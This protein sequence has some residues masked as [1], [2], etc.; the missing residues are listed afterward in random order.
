MLGQGAGGR[1]SAGGTGAAG[2]SSLRNA[3]A[4]VLPFTVVDAEY[5]KSLDSVV[6][7][8]AKPD[9]LH[10]L[11]E[12]GSDIVVALPLAGAAVSV[13]PDGQTAAVGH[14]GWVTEVDLTSGAILQTV[15][16]SAPTLDI[17]LAA[18]HYAYVFPTGNQPTDIRSLNL[19][20]GKEEPT[21]DGMQIQGGTRAKLEPG[22]AAIYGAQNGV[23]EAGLERYDISAG[24]EQYSRAWPYHGDYAA[25]GDLWF[26][27]DGQRIFTRCGE[28]FDATGN[29]DAD[30]TYSGALE[31][32]TG[33]DLVSFVAHSAT[34]HQ[35]IALRGPINF[36]N[37]M[38]IP[39][40][41]TIVV[42]EDVYLQQERAIDATS[43]DGTSSLCSY[44]FA[45]STG[46]HAVLLCNG[47]DGQGSWLVKLA[48]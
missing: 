42:F 14:D 20:T 6:A 22:T 26:S 47:A 4:T 1:A 17:V 11:D 24:A 5:S 29:P 23:S 27:E 21:R 45:S 33:A 12:S 38:P 46:T 13:A 10:V 48:L 18:N 9:E 25:C 30:M 43:I 39:G 15:H 19:T 34:A 3:R 16:V 44:V 28:V 2:A 31:G 37:G 7:L 35:V 40:A 36:F 32:S 41:G 8:A